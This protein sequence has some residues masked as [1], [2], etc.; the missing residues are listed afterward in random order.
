MGQFIG[1]SIGVFL[2]TILLLVVILLV[3]KKY[4][5][6]SGNVNIQINGDTTINVP[7]GSSL[8]TTLNENGIFLPSACGVRYSTARSHTS[9]AR[10]SRT[11]GV[12]DASAR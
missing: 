12:W 11:T 5:S 6:P 8:M 9:R 2:V 10:K 4:L 3:A 1:V 7:Q